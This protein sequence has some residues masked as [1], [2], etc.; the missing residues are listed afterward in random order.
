MEIFASQ[1]APPVSKTPVAKLPPVSTTLAANLRP[2]STT[3]AAKFATSFFC[4]CCWYRWKIFHRCHWYR[5]CH[6][7]PVSTTLEAN[8]PPVSM[9]PVAMG[10]YSVFWN[11]QISK[12]NLKGNGSW[13]KMKTFCYFSHLFSSKLRG[14][15]MQWRHHTSEVHF[16]HLKISRGF[17]IQYLR[18]RT[19]SKIL[20]IFFL[21]L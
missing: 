4:L 6:L 18:G 8:L 9:T 10:S 2:V 13:E 21:F 11:V 7:P 15:C 14:K 3:L 5:W 19:V 16:E 17:F 20:L 12:V 1:G